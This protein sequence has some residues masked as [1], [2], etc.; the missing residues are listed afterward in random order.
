MADFSLPWETDLSADSTGDFASIAGSD[1]V[2]QRIVRRFL[3]N[4]AG[5]DLSGQPLPPSYVFDPSY[6]GGARR[7][8]DKPI[9]QA[10][11]DQVKRLF[12]AQAQLEPEV[13]AD[14]PPVVNVTKNTDG[15]LQITASVFLAGGAVAV[16]PASAPL[17]L[18]V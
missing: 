2:V 15:S 3:S 18:G 16:I 7:L 9:T 14:P 10:V 13:L 6:G 4:P 11:M 5:V 17:L 1:E 12:V 8:V